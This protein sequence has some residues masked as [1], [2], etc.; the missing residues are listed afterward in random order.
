MP[1]IDLSTIPEQSGTNYPAP[2][3]EKVKARRW[4]RVGEAGGLSL[5]GVNLCTIPGGTWSSQMH[6]HSHED[7]FLIVLSGEGRLVTSAGEDTLKRGDMA[8][9][10]AK[11]EAH[12]IRNDGSED[13]VFLVVSNRDERDGCTYPG[14]DMKVG[15]DGIYRRADGTPY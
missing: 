1:K 14:I 12:H 10:P 2:H 6:D 4:K 11:G 13:L 8:A 3:D 15:P 7:E 9:F 5:L